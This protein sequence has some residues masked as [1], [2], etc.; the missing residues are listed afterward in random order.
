MTNRGHRLLDLKLVRTAY[1][2]ASRPTALINF[3]SF[4][5][6][7]GG[8]S[9]HW[10]RAS[11][12][13]QGAAFICQFVQSF[14]LVSYFIW[15]VLKAEHKSLCCMNIITS[16]YCTMEGAVASWLVRSFP[17]RAVRVRAL[18]G[19]IVLCSWARHL[20]LTVPLSIQEY[21]WVPANLMLGI[22]L[23]WTSILSRGWQKYS[24]SLHALE[25]G[26]SSCLVGHLACMQ[27]FPF[28][29]AK[30]PLKFTIRR[31]AES[32]FPINTENLSDKLALVPYSDT[33]VLNWPHSH[34]N[35]HKIENTDC[36]IP[37]NKP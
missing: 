35:S 4:L 2:C 16:S 8:E 28:T 34:N 18:A 33:V 27:T 22:T 26:I 10:K 37:T 29:F 23:G 15:N 17:E 3:D 21:K 30:W 5:Q 11:L 9:A 24:Q 7:R 19:D 13:V 14:W 36:S 12:S 6:G 1:M 32:R 20:T 25:T 31:L